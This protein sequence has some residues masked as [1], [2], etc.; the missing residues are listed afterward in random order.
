MQVKMAMKELEDEEPP[1]HP[2]QKVQFLVRN[3]K[4]DSIQ[5]WTTRGIIND[6]YLVLFENAC[7]TLLLT[8][9]TLFLTIGQ[10]QIKRITRATNANRGQGHGDGQGDGHGH[11]DGWHNHTNIPALSGTC[12]M[13]GNDISNDI[14]FQMNWATFKLLENQR[15][16]GICCGGGG[17]GGRSQNGGQRHAATSTGQDSARKGYI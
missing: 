16:H 6:K 1:H 8:I 14:L 3:I 4:S 13:N 12:L 11:G 10:I 5:V 2:Q 15:K 17:P 7:T 9:S